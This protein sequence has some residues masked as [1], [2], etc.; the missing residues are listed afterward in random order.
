MTEKG[1]AENLI[2]SYFTELN[3][4]LGVTPGYLHTDQGGEFD[5]TTFQNALVSQG[6]SLER[7][8]LHSPQTNGVAEC[9]NQTLLTKISCLLAQYNIPICYWNEAPMHASFLFNH[10]PHKFLDMRSPNDI[11]FGKKLTIQPV[12]SLTKIMPFGVKVLIKKEYPASKTNTTNQAMKALTFEPYS[13]ALRFLDTATGKI[14][15]SQDY[16]QVKSET[17]VMLWKNPSL[18]PTSKNQVNVLTIPLPTLTTFNSPILQV[19]DTST[20][21]DNQMV[22]PAGPS[23]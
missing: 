7:G 1:L 14:K 19:S 23:E 5:S 21:Q 15:V 6:F 17:S 12:F 13:E 10:L 9:F 20:N 16:A 3:N 11:L 2:L 4:K 8:P 18:L 22:N